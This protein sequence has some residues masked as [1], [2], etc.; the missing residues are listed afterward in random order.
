VANELHVSQSA[1][2]NQIRQLEDRL[3]EPLFRKLP[4]QVDS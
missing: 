3:G 1:L 4:H 2:S